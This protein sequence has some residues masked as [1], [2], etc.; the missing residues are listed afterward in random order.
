M[1]NQNLPKQDETNSKPQT[2]R[3]NGTGPRNPNIKR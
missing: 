1:N 3:E 2:E